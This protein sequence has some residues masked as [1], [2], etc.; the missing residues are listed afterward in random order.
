MSKYTLNAEMVSLCEEIKQAK[1]QQDAWAQIVKE[2][3][4]K[5][6]EQLSGAIKETIQELRDHETSPFLKETLPT[7]TGIQFYDQNGREVAE[8]RGVGNKME[9]DD[10]LL[11]ELC[12]AHPAVIGKLVKVSHTPIA[13][14]VLTELR[15]SASAL[16]PLLEE[17]IGAKPSTPTLTIK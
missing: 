16:R 8:L 9:A 12:E 5:L 2:K 7:A 3:K 17:V 1:E 14:S 4:E 11:A 13:R 6:M 15:K 10:I